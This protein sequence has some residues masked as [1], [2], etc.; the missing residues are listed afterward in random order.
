M[1]LNAKP[2]AINHRAALSLFHRLQRSFLRQNNIEIYTNPGNIG[3]PLRF[4][5]SDNFRKLT[6]KVYTL[7]QCKTWIFIMCK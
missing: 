3:L 5:S 6:Q 2:L 7:S 1:P 4:R